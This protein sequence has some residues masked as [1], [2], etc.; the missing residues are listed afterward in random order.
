[1]TIGP[2]TINKL[3]DGNF[4]I[5]VTADGEGGIFPAGKVIDMMMAFYS[6]EF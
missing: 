6:E 5:Y 1:M 4:H 2:F 3:A